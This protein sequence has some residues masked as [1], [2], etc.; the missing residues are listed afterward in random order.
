MIEHTRDF[1]RIRALD[2]D[3]LINIDPEHLY[4]VEV[5]NGQDVG[6][7]YLK[8]Q[9][10]YFDVHVFM[11]AGCRGAEA[12]RSAKWMFDWVWH[13]TAAAGIRAFIPMQYRGVQYLAAQAGMEYL[14][15]DPGGEKWYNI[16]RPPEI[17]MM[18]LAG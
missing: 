13:N 7:W 6:F 15:L 14:H 16:D 8:P 2:P 12:V 1:R 5:R 4:L 11:K 10:P 17:R 3:Y 9:W 18:R